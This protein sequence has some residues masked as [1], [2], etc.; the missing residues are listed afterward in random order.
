MRHRRML[1]TD[2]H[3]TTKN[4]AQGK[5]GEPRHKAGGFLT[6]TGV[7]QADV[8]HRRTEHVHAKNHRHFASKDCTTKNAAQGRDGE[9]RH[10]AGGCL[11]QTG[12]RQAD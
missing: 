11:T 6:Q 3:C 9:P 10:K 2:R 12:V 5:D 4:T 7:R 1:N 8:K